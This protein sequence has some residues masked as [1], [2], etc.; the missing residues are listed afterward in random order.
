MPGP[1][2]AAL[3]RALARRGRPFALISAF[4]TPQRGRCPRHGH[5]QAELVLHSGGAG[6]T[7]TDHGAARFADGDVVVY[8]PGVAHSQACDRAGEDLCL[9]LD[10]GAAAALLPPLLHI[11]GPLPPGLAAEIADLVRTWSGDPLT[12]LAGDHR[13]TAVLVRLLGHRAATA[14][15][16][17]RLA[18]A[19]RRFLGQRLASPVRL[20]DAARE[21]GVGEDRLRRAFTRAFGLSPVAW[22]ARARVDRAR[23]LLAHSALDL[24]AVAAACGLGS[25]R[26]LCAVF[27]RVA[28]TTPGAARRRLDCSA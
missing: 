26:Y 13:A 4:A 9:L 23:E 18:D 21:L 3:A 14:T 24:D 12:R 7:A 8:G 1:D 11:P 27:R 6:T 25:A 22:L 2:P 17:G 20:A 15:G 5:A 10:L 28:G 16:D 19:A